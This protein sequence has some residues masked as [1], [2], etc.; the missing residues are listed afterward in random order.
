M[1][2]SNGRKA[3]DVL[4][5]YVLKKG[6]APPTWARSLAKAYVRRFHPKSAEHAPPRIVFTKSPSP[7]HFCGRHFPKQQAVAIC[8]SGDH[9]VTRGVLVHELTHWMMKQRGDPS[10]AHNQAFYKYVTAA[11]RYFVVPR[12]VQ[13]EIDPQL[14]RRG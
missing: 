2:A 1:T 7:S 5:P 11:Y 12:A 13:L 3:K 10:G 8:D 6:K 9:E 14:A 4:G